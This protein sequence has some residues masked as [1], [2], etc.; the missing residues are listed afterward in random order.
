MGPWAARKVLKSIGN[1]WF[2]AKEGSQKGAW[3][4]LQKLPDGSA[5]S[6]E[7][8]GSKTEWRGAPAPPRGPLGAPKR[9]DYH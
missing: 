8:E 4:K 2:C 7:T 9:A 6:S 3:E 1:M 5:G